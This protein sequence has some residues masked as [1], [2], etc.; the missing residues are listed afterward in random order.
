[1]SRGFQG[2]I[3][4]ER[5]VTRAHAGLAVLPRR[6]P[7]RPPAR[8][9]ARLGRKRD[10]LFVSRVKNPAGFDLISDLSEVKGVVYFAWASASSPAA[11]FRFL[12]NK[13]T[14]V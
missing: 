5:Q 9:A 13:D 12:P 1:M 8:S 3:S 14:S 11:R 7:R 2:N 4:G 6:P 10:R